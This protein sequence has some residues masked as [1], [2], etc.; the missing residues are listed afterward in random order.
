VDFGPL[1][2]GFEGRERE[3]RLDLL[4]RLHE[5]GCTLEELEAASAAGRLPLLPVERLLARRRRHSLSGGGS[6]R[7][8]RGHQPPHAR[9]AFADR[10]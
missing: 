5:D 8:L 3:A 6:A 1:L 2:E 7:G 10:R 9:P 4:R